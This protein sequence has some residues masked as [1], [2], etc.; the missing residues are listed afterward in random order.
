MDTTVYQ[1]DHA[2]NKIPPQ[3]ARITQARSFY[4][5]MITPCIGVCQVRDNRCQGCGRTLEEIGQWIYYSDQEREAVMERLE[6]E[7]HTRDQR[8]LS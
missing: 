6:N 1:P 7:K 5:Q 2:G 8:W 3:T 4:L